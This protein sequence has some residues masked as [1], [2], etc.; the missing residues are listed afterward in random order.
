LKLGQATVPDAQQAPTPK[1]EL[2]PRSAIWQFSPLPQQ[3]ISGVEPLNVGQATFP[4]AQQKPIVVP[5]SVM[6]EQAWLLGQ[7]I[8]PPVV[9]QRRSDGQQKPS[10]PQCGS[11]DEHAVVDGAS[12]KP[13]LPLA[14]SHVPI[15][16]G[17]LLGQVF[18]VPGLHAPAW[19]VSFVQALLSA[20]Q[21]IPLVF[22]CLMQLPVAGSHAPVL[23]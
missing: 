16:Q 3:T 23:H 11:P 20:L 12:V 14:V 1:G 18:G 10:S 2:G 5:F 15:R 17:P 9:S 7:Q 22:G 21:A 8:V 4:V 19:H 6:V 13:Q